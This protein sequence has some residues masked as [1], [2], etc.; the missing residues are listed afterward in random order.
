VKT[1]IYV[2][3]EDPISGYSAAFE[4]DGRVAYGYLLDPDQK[5]IRDVWLYNRCTTPREPEWQTPDLLPFANPMDYA[6]DHSGFTPVQDASDVTVAWVW[7][8]DNR[9]HAI[10]SIR[11]DV[12]G[13]IENGTKPGWARMAAKDGPLAK[14][15]EV[16]D[17]G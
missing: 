1:D 7:L 14:V 15:L 9:M 4:D 5:I 17:L 6:R 2:D 11:G 16:S 12:F 13:I 3:F 8:N 10:I